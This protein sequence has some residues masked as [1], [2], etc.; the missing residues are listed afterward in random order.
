VSAIVTGAVQLKINQSNLK[1]L[2]FVRAS[3]E[4]NQSF[5]SLISPLFGRI[6]TKT[7]ENLNLSDFA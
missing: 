3:S 1:T 2:P 5:S 7:E 4:I 6:R